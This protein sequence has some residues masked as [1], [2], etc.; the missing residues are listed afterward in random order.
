[1]FTKTSA[2]AQN[3]YFKSVASSGPKSYAK[4]IVDVDNKAINYLFSYDR[5]VF[6]TAKSGITM[7]AVAQEPDGRFEKFMLHGSIKINP[8]VY[9]NII[10]VSDESQVIFKQSVAS[11][12]SKHP[13]T[14]SLEWQSIEQQVQIDEIFTLYY[15]VKKAPYHFPTESHNYCELTIVEQG[16][17][18]T[19]VDGISYHLERN[20]AILYQ[21][22]QSHSQSVVVD[23]TTTYITILFNMTLLDTQFFDRVF[24]LTQ[25]Q[26]AQLETFVRISEEENKPYKNDLLLGHLKLFILSLIFES[27]SQ[28]EQS[29]PISSMKEKY[30]QDIFQKLT[31]YIKEKPDIRVADL[32]ETFG[33]SRS[34]IQTLFQRF[35]GM[36]PHTY[37]GQ[38][39]LKQAKILMRDS[40]Y[41][42]AEIAVLSGYSSLPAFSRAFKTTFGYSPSQYS[43][44]L[45]KQI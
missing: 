35:M 45:Y 15:Q 14:A 31:A 17:L 23:K 18:E 11:K 4:K 2:I 44:K 33:I 8:H 12:I 24:H 25:G 22:N 39:R 3:S 40:S 26:I 38:Q 21:R 10:S 41:S 34:N 36:A 5:P 29:S 37:I 9:F 13:L 30:D 20:D 1:M 16:S 32:S 19:T 43:K 27:S 7:L 28:T 6:L 42:L